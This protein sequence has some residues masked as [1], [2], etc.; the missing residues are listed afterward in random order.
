MGYLSPDKILT[1]AW[2]IP[3]TTFSGTAYKTILCSFCTFKL[4]WYSSPYKIL[5]G[6]WSIAH[7]TLSHDICLL[8]LFVAR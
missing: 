3:H 1:E 7:I 5:I 6:A 2:S 4:M 8:A